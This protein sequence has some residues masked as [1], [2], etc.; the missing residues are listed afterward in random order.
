MSGAYV[1]L[2]DK[3]VEL[4]DEDVYTEDQAEKYKELRSIMEKANLLAKSLKNDYSNEITNEYVNNLA[5]GL[6]YLTIELDIA[7]S[8]HEGCEASD[9]GELLPT[10]DPDDDTESWWDEDEVKYTADVGEEEVEEVETAGA[11]EA[12]D[13]N[14][15][16]DTKKR[17]KKSDSANKKTK[18]TGEEDATSKSDLKDQFIEAKALP[19]NN[20]IY[21]PARKS[22]EKNI[23]LACIAIIWPTGRSA[24]TAKVA[25]MGRGVATVYKSLSHGDLIFNTS[26]K[27]VR[28]TY[29]RAKKNV[30]KAENQAIADVSKS[31]NFD[32]FALV[33]GGVTKGSN[34]GKKYAHLNGTLLRTGLHEIGHLLGLG[35]AG[36]YINGKLDDYGDGT[37][38]MGKYATDKLN[39]PQLYFFGWVAANKTAQYNIGSPTTTYNVEY[40]YVDKPSDSNVSGV[41]IPRKNGRSLFF[42]IA[43]IGGKMLGCVHYILNNGA[44]TQRAKAF[45]TK[46]EVEE[47]TFERVENNGS[48]AKFS[49]GTKLTA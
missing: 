43:P 33:N 30:S 6:N 3:D 5:D 31:K 21:A 13:D 19:S 8:A 28:V 25:S 18:H 42:S 7:D 38:F 27:G 44:G 10:F 4:Q 34:A 14:K 32:M 12:E 23:A 35:H 16:D 37:S 47:L 36:A 40:S 29:N 9:K 26:A 17:S 46:T 22:F 48:F 41:L 11:I 2:Q 49:I 45:N 24:S 15:I 39:A 1:A 20:I